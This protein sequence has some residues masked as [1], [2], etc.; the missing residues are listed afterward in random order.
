V[1]ATPK[2]TCHN[3]DAGFEVRHL[4]AEMWINPCESA[5]SNVRRCRWTDARNAAR[6]P[7]ARAK[8]STEKE[9]CSLVQKCAFFWR[10]AHSAMSGTVARFEIAEHPA[11]DPTHLSARMGRDV[12]IRYS[13]VGVISSAR[14][15]EPSSGRLL[16]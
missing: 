12:R 8:I 4:R 5:I 14:S 6:D 13:T 7:Q 11:A 9:F 16:R 15:A 3:L 2:S 1:K 10:C